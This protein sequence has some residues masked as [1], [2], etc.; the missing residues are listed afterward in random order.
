MASLYRCAYATI[1]PSFLGPTNIPPL[2]AI[3]LRCPV[4]CS[5][6]YAMKKQLGK[7]A[8]YFNPK[9]PKEIANQIQTLIKTK[10]MRQKLIYQGKMR[11]NKYNEKHFRKK[12]ENFL[13]KLA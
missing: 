11:H 2:E 3:S 13:L 12:L 4:I 1:Y 7:S 6:K 5:N 10:N 8:L 9:S